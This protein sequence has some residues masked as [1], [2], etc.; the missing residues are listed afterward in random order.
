MMRI[1]TADRQDSEHV[2]RLVA[3]AIDDLTELYTGAADSAEALRRLRAFAELDECRFSYSNVLLA[4]TDGTVCGGAL[5]YP[6]DRLDVLDAP[7]LTFLRQFGPVESLPAECEGREIYLD[8]IAVYPAFQGMGVGGQLLE[9]V[10][11]RT[12]QMGYPQ[13][14]LLVDVDK[15]RV[16]ELYARHGFRPDGK[17]TVYGHTYTRMV[18]PE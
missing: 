15:P 13:T 1:R 17:R 4:E 14:S 6:A 8:S 7:I 5:Y 18:R 12:G 10:C 9:A 11:S 3:L 2:A 16:R